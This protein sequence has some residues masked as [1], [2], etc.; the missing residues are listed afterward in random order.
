MGFEG[1]DGWKS[2]A[3]IEREEQPAAEEFLPRY[4]LQLSYD[5]YFQTTRAVLLVSLS[6]YGWREL[7]SAVVAGNDNAKAISKLREGRRYWQA[8]ARAAS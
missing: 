5:R 2:S 1:Y 3:P 6:D 8:A 7:D 4:R